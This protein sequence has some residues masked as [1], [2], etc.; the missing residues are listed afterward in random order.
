MQIRIRR[1]WFQPLLFVLASIQFLFSQVPQSNP[2]ALSLAAQS[3]AAMS[4]GTNVQDV[5]V[6]GNAIW[7]SGSTTQTG[8]ANLLAKGT[9]ESRMDLTING[10]TQSE[11]RSNSSGMSQGEWVAN[12]GIS[13][14]Y[15]MHNCWTDSVWFF[16]ILSSLSGTNPSVVLSYAGSETRSGVSV[17]HLHSYFYLPAKKPDLTILAQNASAIDFYIDSASLLPVAIVFNAHP[18]DD[19]ARNIAV[20]V[21]FSNYQAANGVLVSRHIQKYV[22]GTLVLDFTVTGV[23]LNTG[24]SD[25]L[26]A[27]Q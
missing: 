25:N 14:P 21:D 10:T 9:G 1:R 23:A 4:G 7:T 17:Q 6:S 26:F 3:L 13:T 2:Q 11:I 18:D 15:A 16:P 12:D 22:Q 27:I 5:T 20:E 24:L 19:A 8:T